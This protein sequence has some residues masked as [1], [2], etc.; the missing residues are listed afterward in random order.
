MRDKTCDLEMW[1][2]HGYYP[3]LALG[4]WEPD[5]MAHHLSFARFRNANLLAIG[6]SKEFSWTN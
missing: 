4:M 1:A 2:E 3:D 5:G 6:F